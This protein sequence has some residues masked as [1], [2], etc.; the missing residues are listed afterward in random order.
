VF[1]P[2]APLLK[3]ELAGEKSPA[4]FSSAYRIEAPSDEFVKLAQA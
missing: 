2:D 1:A 4:F 3:V